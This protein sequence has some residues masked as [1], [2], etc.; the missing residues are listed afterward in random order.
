[1]EQAARNPITIEPAV[2]GV[3]FSAGERRKVFVLEPGSRSRAVH[4]LLKE[5]ASAMADGL[6]VNVQVSDPVGVEDL[7]STRTPK[8]KLK[9]QDVFLEFGVPV[10]TLQSWRRQG[11]G[12]AYSKVGASIYYDRQELESF[13]KRHTIATTGGA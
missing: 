5:V 7:V 6:E 1:M 11:L 4:D 8:V 12:P 2:N 10:K 13:F 3:I 9:E